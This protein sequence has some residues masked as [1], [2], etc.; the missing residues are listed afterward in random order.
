MTS[1]E[2]RRAVAG[3]KPLKRAKRV[4]LKAPPPAPVP[5]QRRRDEAAALAE[6]L[7]GPLSVDDA[8]DAGEEPYLRDG[9]PRQLLRKLRRGDWA[10]QDGVDLHGLT[11]E[12]ASAVVVEFLEQCLARG[13]RCV[14]IVH[15]KGLGIL[16]A[17]LRRWL[18]QREE[19][20]AYCQAPATE[21]GGGALL[22]LLK[23]KR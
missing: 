19:V 12:Q 14:R 17:K 5:T 23:A 9:L 10:I 16:K 20:L 7:S 3:V 6:S 4:A 11:R 21:G 1:D 15:G 22:V 13:L 2:F 8:L 18:P